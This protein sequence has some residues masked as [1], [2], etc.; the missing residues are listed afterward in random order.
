LT[1]I[2][3]STA[4][5]G[6]ALLVRAVGNALADYYGFRKANFTVAALLTPIRKRSEKKLAKRGQRHKKLAAVVKQDNIEVAVSPSGR[7]CPGRS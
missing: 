2:L 4:K 7:I 5:I 3:G 6:W 1:K